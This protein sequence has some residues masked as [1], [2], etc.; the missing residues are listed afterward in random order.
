M[1]QPSNWQESGCLQVEYGVVGVP[2]TALE[3]RY[4]VYA[5]DDDHSRVEYSGGWR[6]DP[7]GSIPISMLPLRPTWPGF[8]LNTV[9]YALIAWCLWQLPPAIRRRQ[10]RRNGF[11]VRCG[12]DLKGLAPAAP[13]PECGTQP[14][15]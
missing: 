10:R 3:W 1:F 6:F 15:A 5:I 9:F 4:L 12:Y 14:R 13:C 7:N 2:W 11:C 8:A